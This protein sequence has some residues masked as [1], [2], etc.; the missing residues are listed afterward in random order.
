MYA[1][2]RHRHRHS[3]SNP[4]INQTNIHIE[5]KIAITDRIIMGDTPRY[6]SSGAPLWLDETCPHQSFYFLT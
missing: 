4:S 6:R 1:H 3:N 5:I 2:N